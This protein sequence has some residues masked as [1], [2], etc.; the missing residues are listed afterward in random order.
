MVK[1]ANPK[2]E[3]NDRDY[4][5]ITFVIKNLP[6]GII[7]LLLAVIFSAAMSSKSSELNALATSSVIDFYRRSFRPNETDDHYMHVSKWMTAFW[8]VFAIGFALSA[9]LFENLIEAVNIIGSLF[10]GTIL[11]IFMFAFF[12]KWVKSKAVFWAAVLSETII[13]GIFIQFGY[14]NKNFQYLWLNLLGCVLVMVI[15]LLF[16][17]FQKPTTENIS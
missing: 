12:V 4:V 3:T 9:Q 5:F 11:G 7:G 17:S 14:K 8:G 1:K 10:Y 13:V 6:V 15:A 16:Q 2:A